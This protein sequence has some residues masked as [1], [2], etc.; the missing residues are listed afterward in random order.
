MATKFEL[1]FEGAV[2]LQQVIASF[3]SS[4]SL[5]LVSARIIHKQ[6][7]E[8]TDSS[9]SF[10]LERIPLIHQKLLD[11]LISTPTHTVTVSEFIRM[12]GIEN[13]AA[14][15]RGAGKSKNSAQHVLYTMDWIFP[16]GKRI[17]RYFLTEEGKKIMKIT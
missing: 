1:E 3:S 2:S 16:D 4:I 13:F 15:M 10:K 11:V 8:E 17:R 9:D 5:N 6:K 14:Q 12:T 7:Q